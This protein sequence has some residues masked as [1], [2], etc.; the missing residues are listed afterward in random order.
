MSRPLSYIHLSIH[1]H[2]TRSPRNIE[3]PGDCSTQ[4]CEIDPSM[5]SSLKK[6]L[7]LINRRRREV[8][9][10]G[11]DR[12]QRT[13]A[14]KRLARDGRR[15]TAPRARSRS[16]LQTLRRI[17]HRTNPYILHF[18]ISADVIEHRSIVAEMGEESTRSADEV[19]E[20]GEGANHED[21]EAEGELQ[22]GGVG[23][24]EGAVFVP[25]LGHTS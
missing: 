7:Q 11:L 18:D 15:K 17:F 4:A 24:R 20:D 25:R 14:S 2:C 12:E 16:R 6:Q 23:A 9:L 10:C 19:E 1:P 8:H 3:P 22:V 21:D 13:L 5:N